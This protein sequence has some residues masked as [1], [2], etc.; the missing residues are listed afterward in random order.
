M[1]ESQ[2]KLLNVFAR[3]LVETFHLYQGLGCLFNS[4]VTP[5][6]NPYFPFVTDSSSASRKRKYLK[7]SKTAIK[8]ALTGLFWH[9]AISLKCLVF[10]LVPG[11][12]SELSSVADFLCSSQKKRC[13]VETLFQ[14]MNWPV[15]YTPL[16]PVYP[17]QSC[18]FP[19][20]HFLHALLRLVILL[21]FSIIPAPQCRVRAALLL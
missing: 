3:F 21:S 15:S 17:F 5:C 10:I 20:L 7:L 6:L 19:F 16:Y 4:K 13:H 11:P 18:S 14:P 8:N 1:H 2:S 12:E 9:L